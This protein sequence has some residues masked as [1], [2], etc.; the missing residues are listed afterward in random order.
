MAD[1]AALSAIAAKRARQAP[2]RSGKAIPVMA[3]TWIGTEM[4]LPANDAAV[5]VPATTSMANAYSVLCLRLRNGQLD[6][7]PIGHITA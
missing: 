2:L 7:C 6:F 1:P 3:S 5:R 4:A